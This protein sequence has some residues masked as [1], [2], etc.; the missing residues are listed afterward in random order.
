MIYH[1]PT[2]YM[3]LYIKLYTLF[4]LAKTSNHKYVLKIK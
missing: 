2:Y 1:K 3:L 4:V